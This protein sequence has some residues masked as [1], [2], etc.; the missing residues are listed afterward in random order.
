MNIIIIYYIDCICICIQYIYPNYIY[1]YI[2]MYL[3]IWNEEK[4]L[5]N[6]QINK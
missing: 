6:T 3:L 4:K 2:T 1:I 5:L